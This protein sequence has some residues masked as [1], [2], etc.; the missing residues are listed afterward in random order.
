MSLAELIEDLS[1][2]GL[3]EYDSFVAAIDLVKT[4]KLKRIIGGEFAFREEK[5]QRVLQASENLSRQEE[6]MYNT[7]TGLS[8]REKQC[9][10]KHTI[11]NKTYQQIADE[12][13]IT[14]SAVQTYIERARNKIKNTEAIS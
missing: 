10:L 9:F 5:L 1:E 8:K 13:Q 14:K 4:E 3:L 6:I 7:L 2:N 11:E 12:L